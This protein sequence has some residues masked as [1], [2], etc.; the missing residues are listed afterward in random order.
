MWEFCSFDWINGLRSDATLVSYT[1]I[2][3]FYA[4]LLFKIC[5]IFYETTRINIKCKHQKVWSKQ[6]CKTSL[7]WSNETKMWKHRDLKRNSY[8]SHC[9][10]VMWKM[11]LIHVT[12]KSICPILWQS[13]ND[14]KIVLLDFTEE[15]QKDDNLRV[16]IWR[17]KNNFSSPLWLWP[18]VTS[19][20][21][22]LGLLGIL[23]KQNK[24]MKIS[25]QL[26]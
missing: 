16:I 14:W 6:L 5:L 9:R 2:F 15:S 8:Y 3:L 11:S 19:Q 21:L 10:H 25:S 24:L 22:V 13:T 7:L 26:T 17:N 1:I 4:L 18:F 12:A 23:H 20:W